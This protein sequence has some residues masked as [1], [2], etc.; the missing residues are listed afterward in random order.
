MAL[1]FRNTVEP[2]RFVEVSGWEVV[3]M[4]FVKGVI[5]YH[6]ERYKESTES[7]GFA[8]GEYD[9]KKRKIQRRCPY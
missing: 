1:E 8:L 4:Y 3:H 6:L 7:F 2:P 5:L 9:K